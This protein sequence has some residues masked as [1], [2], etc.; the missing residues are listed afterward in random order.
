M[1]GVK[2]SLASKEMGTGL[3]NQNKIKQNRDSK[4][5]DGL[6][7][8]TTMSSFLL[9]TFI[10]TVRPFSTLLPIVTPSHL[11][12]PSSFGPNFTSLVRQVW[13]KVSAAEPYNLSSILGPRG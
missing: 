12:K 5:W 3:K 11:P 10:N 4:A 7:L 13:V 9:K 8:W 6:Y 2:T 1:L